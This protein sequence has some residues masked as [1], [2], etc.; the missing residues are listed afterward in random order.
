[1]TEALVSTAALLAADVVEWNLATRCL[2]LAWLAI[3]GAS[4]GSFMNVVVY[5]LPAGLS[6]VHPG[7][8]CPRCLHPIRGKDNVPVLSWLLLR[9]RCRDC[10]TPISARY[11]SVEAAA[12]IVTLLVAFCEL[13]PLDW[14]P[15]ALQ[16]H[17]RAPLDQVSAAVG[18]ATHVLLLLTLMCGALIEY[19]GHEPPLRLFG[20]VLLV[21]LF[22]AIAYPAT[23]DFWP[24]SRASNF[25]S[26]PLAGLIG[27]LVGAGAGSFVGRFVLNTPGAARGRATY[28]LAFAAVG[29]CLG[30]TAAIAAAVAAWGTLVA[31]KLLRRGTAIPL[32]FST[33]VV[34]GMIVAVRWWE[35]A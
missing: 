11:P 19:D 12:M 30:A 18:C 24:M 31:S 17:G 6:I 25:E 34:L 7:S 9:G 8:R 1:M 2:V 27:G 28:A 13:V 16:P 10:G 4:V 20:P 32:A 29:L 5:R 26:G 23:G 22:V 35:R 15:A 3:V 14:L 33:L 21:G